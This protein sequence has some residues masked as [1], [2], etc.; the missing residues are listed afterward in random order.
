M[1]VAEVDSSRRIKFFI[2][3]RLR[4][5]SST[6]ADNTF[7]RNS[8]TRFTV[9]QWCGVKAN[10]ALAFERPDMRWGKT[11]SNSTRHSF[12]LIFSRCFAQ[13]QL[14]EGFIR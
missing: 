12:R 10:L 13:Q 5:M 6:R 1:M 3:L 14:S 2:S 4:W 8:Y 9:R 7:L 11:P